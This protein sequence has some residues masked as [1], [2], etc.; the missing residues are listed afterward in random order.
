MYFVQTPGSYPAD[1]TSLTGT[2]TT[3]LFRAPMIDALRPVSLNVLAVDSK[4]MS[5]VNRVPFGPLIRLL[6][7][8]DTR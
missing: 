6:R 2:N 7:N 5:T 4:N 1:L 8:V 3:Y